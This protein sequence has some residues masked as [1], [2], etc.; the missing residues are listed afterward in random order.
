MLT[1][2]VNQRGGGAV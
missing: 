1:E 2:G